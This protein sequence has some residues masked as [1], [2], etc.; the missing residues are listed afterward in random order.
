MKNKNICYNLDITAFGKF[1]FKDFDIAK[2]T[3]FFG[4]NESGKST[5]FDA[6]LSA[7]SKIDKTKYY[8][9]IKKR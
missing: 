4:E 8:G 5:M 7:F 9:E 2:T 6:L 3:V 1:V